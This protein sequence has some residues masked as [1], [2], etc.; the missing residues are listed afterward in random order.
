MLCMLESFKLAN[1]NKRPLELK[2]NMRFG[3]REANLKVTN[4]SPI[5]RARISKLL[6]RP[7]IDS[8]E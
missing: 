2:H 7:G 8:K 3:A 5:S 1:V 4:H 6:R